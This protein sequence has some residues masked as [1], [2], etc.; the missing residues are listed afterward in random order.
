MSGWRLRLLGAGAGVL[1]VVV[2]G[3]THVSPRLS[4]LANSHGDTA[5]PHYDVSVDRDSVHRAGEILR[6]DGGTYY[7]YAPAGAPVLLGNLGAAIR[8]WAVPALPLA[9]PAEARWVFSYQT[10][11]LLP[12]GLHARRVYKFGNRIALVEVRG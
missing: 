2:L 4:T 10:P 7:V 12:P 1:L 5:D 3:A 8:L 6:R 11:R 9:S